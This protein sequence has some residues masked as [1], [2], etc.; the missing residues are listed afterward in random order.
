MTNRKTFLF[1]ILLLSASLLF[2]TSRS[3]A[4]TDILNFQQAFK[5]DKQLYGGIL[6]DRDGFLWLG[7]SG[8]VLKSDGYESQSLSSITTAGVEV[9]LEDRNGELWFGGR[10][11]G[12]SR[13]NKDTDSVTVYS[14]NPQNPESLSG[15]AVSAI[16]EDRDGELWIGT[17]TDGLNRLRRGEHVTFEHFRHDPQ[18]PQSLSNDRITSLLEDSEGFLWIGSKEGGLNRFDKRTGS[19][20]HY[21]H[22]TD[23]PESLS[24]DYV[25]CLLEDRDG[26]IWVGTNSR[27]LNRFDRQN[28]VFTQYRHDADDPDSLSND[29]V[30]SLYEDRAGFLWVGRWMT[31]SGLDRFEKK[32]GRFTNYRHDPKDPGS[33]SSDL[34]LKVY[35][36]R[37]GAMLVLC[38]T[39]EVDIYDENRQHFRVYTHQPD[40]PGSLQHDIVV[41]LYEDRAGEFWLGGP[42]GG[43]QR[44]DRQTEAFVQYPS[45]PDN[46]TALQG[47]YPPAIFEDSAGDFWVGTWG[48]TLS[49]FDRQRG[50]ARKHYTP[51]PGLTDSSEHIIPSQTVWTIV[52]D[53]ED[54]KLLWLGTRGGGLERF[55]KQ[56]ESFR[57]Y[58]YEAENEQSLSNNEVW[59]LYDDGEGGLWIATTEGLNYLDKSRNQFTRYTHNNSH[60]RITDIH[61]DSSDTTLLWL[62]T[63]GGGLLS[64]NRKSRSF[65]RHYTINDGLPHNSIGAIL[66]ERNGVLWLGSSDGLARFVPE[67][68]QIQS[69][70]RQNALLATSVTLGSG[71]KTRDEQIFFGTMEGLIRFTPNSAAPDPYQ[72]PVVL[73]AFMQG[74]ETLALAKAP[75]RVKAVSLSWRQNFFEFEYSAPDFT[76]SGSLHYKYMLEGWDNNWYYAGTK[77]TGRYSGLPGGSYRLKILASNSSGVWNGQVAEIK[78]RIIPPFWQT[79]WFRLLSGLAVLG[80]IVAALILRERSTQKHNALLERQVA[81]RTRALGDKTDELTQVN[82]QLQQSKEKAEV[83]TRAKSAFLANM[84]HELRTPLNAILG[85]SQILTHQRELNHESREDVDI[86]LRN[87]GHLLALIN[88]LLDLSKIEAGRMSLH[89]KKFDLYDLLNDI[90]TTF[91]L[92]AK[93]KNLRL[94]FDGTQDIPRYIKADE[95][96]FRQIFFNLL[97]NALKFTREG[98]VA[99]RIKSERVPIHNEALDDLYPRIVLHVEIEDSGPGIVLEEM[100]HVFESFGQSRTGQYHYQE[101]SGLGLPLSRNFAELMGGTLKISSKPGTGTLCKFHILA[102]EADAADE[103]E[104]KSRRR[105]IALAP[106]QPAFRLLIVDDKPD[107]RSLLKTLLAPLGFELKEAADGREALELWELWEPHLIWMDMRMPVMNGYEATERIK[108][109]IKGQACA[110]IAFTASAFEEEKAIVLSAG[111][112]DFLR[113][114]FRT[115]EIFEMLE[116]HLGIQ[117]IYEEEAPT[118]TDVQQQQMKKLLT[119][120][121]IACFPERWRGDFQNAILIADLDAALELVEEIRSGNEPV[122]DC[123]STLLKNYKF[124]MLHTHFQLFET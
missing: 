67:T 23:K 97:G 40:T 73:T 103:H 69:Y 113:K 60:H 84:S 1:S 120:E 26:E 15:N 110:V 32:S 123:L 62:G 44:F 76:N 83:A 101:G 47:V 111:C 80:A 100:E 19:F 74:G 88:N 3:A 63:D 98:G 21:R 42:I 89:E 77:R 109:N 114:P 9:I 59:D 121:T 104:S 10:N 70:T 94:L 116:K 25:R 54:A 43:L 105:V 35:E 95:L 27:G 106:N 56:D 4:E 48:G 31:P 34:V 11:G 18:N 29:Q 112:N 75:E 65:E 61:A 82:R 53:A 99:I 49:L 87:G 57:H 118:A 36:D 119:A 58:C 33:V 2:S 24:E 86:I 8:G 91:R 107:N 22:Q 122:A 92:K 85:F 78:I 115:S 5:Y 124:T 71:L 93:E 37:S 20:S 13:Y 108:A 6:Q 39:G 64:F 79:E 52:E 90:V 81:E 14:H 117:F 30:Y 16:L 55:N 66:E 102:A 96:K 72:P 51:V 7:T 50:Q 28:G 38:M 41:S 45:D 12:L 17:K 46:P 68:G